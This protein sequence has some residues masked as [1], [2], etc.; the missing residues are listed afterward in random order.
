MLD[1]TTPQIQPACNDLRDQENFML[2]SDS[3][4]C[5][6]VFGEKIKSN[7]LGPLAVKTTSK[8]NIKKGKCI[9]VNIQSSFTT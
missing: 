9:L 1:Q 7:P 2:H 5:Y 4:C 3:V 8:A 6:S